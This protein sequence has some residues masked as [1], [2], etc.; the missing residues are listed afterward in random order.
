LSDIKFGVGEL[1]GFKFFKAVQER[2]NLRNIPFV[3]MSALQDG[4]IIRSGVQ[5]GID[6]Y[7]TKPMDPDLLIATIEGKLKRFRNIQRN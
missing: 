6:D 7:I 3:F 4:V 2:E 1:D 5:L